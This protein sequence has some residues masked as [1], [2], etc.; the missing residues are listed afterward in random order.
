VLVAARRTPFGTAGHRL[1]GQTAV[2]IAA[3]LLADVA[4]RV[5]VIDRPVDEVILGNCLG[6]GGNVAR[7][8][9]LA[10][11]LG[12]EVPAVT[13]DRQCASG[14]E[15]IASAVRAVRGED[16]VLVLAGG[17]E[18]ASTA[19]W[20]HW[21]PDTDHPAPR[22][23]ARAP[24]APQGWPDPDMGTAAD[25]LAVRLGIS[26]R[27]QDEYA[28]DSHARAAAAI[29]AGRFADE[30]LP[31]GGLSRDERP[32]AG[33]TV[34][35]LQRLRPAFGPDGTATAG[36]SSGISDGAAAMAVTTADL[37]RRADLPALQV[38]GGAV[39]AR[40]PTVPGM[41]IAP[42][43]RRAL[44]HSGIDV[45]DV[46]ALEVTEAFASVALACISDLGFDRDLVCSE[47]GAI[48]L[49]HPWGASG[50]AL[51]VRLA[52]RML[53]EDGPEI[54]VAACASGGGLGM[55]MV[56]RRIGAR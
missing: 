40:D 19:P 54:G 45:A 32:R 43:I 11:G 33:L 42:V 29:A 7:V 6:P 8:S 51:L 36:N 12:A 17:V 39:I 25:D 31:V 35:R 22:R 23:Y 20:R 4:S 52:T 10:A 53:T 55:A 18:S 2:D 24:F 37:A 28:A 15:A 44:Q 14:L 49:G 30:I 3:P 56:V 5:A 13:V 34:G 47:G 48:A 9:V 38:L 16:A 21:P 50:A 26:R 27:A 46:G 41:T 1:A